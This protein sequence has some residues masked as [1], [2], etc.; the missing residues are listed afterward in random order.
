MALTPKTSTTTMI[1]IIEAVATVSVV[2]ISISLLKY[3]ST[4]VT[5]LIVHGTPT[6]C[7]FMVQFLYSATNNVKLALN[8]HL[9]QTTL[10]LRS[11][12]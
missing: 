9:C 11:Q 12:K 6:T 10:K 4:G 7:D 8:Y 2:F 3:F 5:F 1:V